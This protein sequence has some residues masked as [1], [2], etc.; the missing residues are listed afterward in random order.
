MADYLN[1]HYACVPPMRSPMPKPDD[2]QRTQAQKFRDLA[3]EVEAD[4]D[5]TEFDAL[6]KG[7]KGVKP[8][9]KEEAFEAK[10]KGNAE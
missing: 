3:R 2:D 4:M 6:V 5:A 10:R 8:P 9:T 1:A 7:S